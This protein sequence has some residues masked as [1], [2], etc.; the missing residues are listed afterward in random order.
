[1]DKKI[2]ALI[3]AAAALG[4]ADAVAAPAPAQ[5]TLA[6]ASNAEL[7]DA[8]P[9]ASSVLASV[10]AAP[11]VQ[12]AQYYYEHHHHHHHHRY[13]G[14]PPIMREFL[15][16]HHHHHHHRYRHHYRDWDD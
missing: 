16:H 2:A 13:R 15:P 3:G 12:L 6:P 14:I 8:V 11:R 5:P 10:D 7:L 4:A 1:M 9:N